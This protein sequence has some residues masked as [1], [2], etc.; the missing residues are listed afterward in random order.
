MQILWFTKVT[1]ILNMGITKE[2][3][4]KHDSPLVNLSYLPGRQEHEQILLA[5]LVLIYTKL[6][7]KNKKKLF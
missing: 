1:R 6:P 2:R 3:E 7:P 4:L 5:R